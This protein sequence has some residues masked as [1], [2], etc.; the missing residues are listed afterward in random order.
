MADLQWQIQQHPALNPTRCVVDSVIPKPTRQ[1]SY[2]KLACS[3]AQISHIPK[4]EG[5]SLNRQREAFDTLCTFAKYGPH[6]QVDT[7]TFN[8]SLTM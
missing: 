8:T 5:I 3:L 1:Q 6:C 4:D 2:V 7:D